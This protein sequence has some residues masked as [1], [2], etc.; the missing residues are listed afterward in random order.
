[1]GGLTETTKREFA[2]RI[3]EVMN[4]STEELQSGGVDISVKSTELSGQVEAAFSAEERQLRARADAEAATRASQ[5]ATNSAYNS[6]SSA[7]DLIVGALGKSNTLS[8]RLR[9]IRDEIANEN[10]IKLVSY[11]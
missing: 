3:P 8:I 9:G 10:Y 2:K 5:E 11:A 6:A 1:M 7:V 4:G